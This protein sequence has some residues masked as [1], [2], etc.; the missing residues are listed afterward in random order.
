MESNAMKR[1]IT[2]TAA[3]S[4][5][6]VPEEI[7]ESAWDDVAASFDRFCLTAGIASLAQMMGEDAEMLCGPRYGRGE[8]RR[9]HRWGTTKG[10][11]GF[12]GG[13]V[14]IER[15]RVRGRDGK[16]LPLPSWEEVRSNGLLEEWAMNLMLINVSTRKFG[17]AVR[18]PKG[19]VPAPKGAGISRS[20]VSR[21]FKAL[22]EARLDEWMSSDLS[23]LDLL[24]IQIDGLNLDDT[25]LMIGAVGVDVTG[26]KHPLAVV[27]GATENTAVV[28]ALLDNLIERGM[29]PT[30]C[31]LFVVDGAKALTKAI[32]RT[33]GADIP[34]QRCQIH[35]AR[36]IVERLAPE[37][38]AGVRRTLRQA[39]ELDDADKAE[40]LLRALARRLELEAPGVSKSILEGLDEILTVTRLGLPIELRRSLACTNIIESMNS[41]IRQVCRNVK[42]WRDARMALRWTGAA[43]LEARK[44]FRRLKAHKQLPVLKA[45]L[46][47]HRAPAAHATSVDAKSKAA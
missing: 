13:K 1:I 37:L 29:D 5:A 11:A 46:E 42:R 15:P 32:R 19:D 30:V 43:M 25:L 38:Q 21:R 28:Q 39:W 33:F 27:E 20:A 12:H 16:E 26:E 4:T 17:R 8:E 23:Q 31:R 2:T 3:A 35:K 14:A 44:G 36:N 41:V 34:I 40:R 24:V 6:V 7:V 45:A 22:T 47:A 18:L 9:G 10:V